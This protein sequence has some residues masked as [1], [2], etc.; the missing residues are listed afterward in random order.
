MVLHVGRA[1]DPSRELGQV[2]AADVLELAAALEF[3]GDRDKVNRVA[4]LEQCQDRCVRLRM[5]ALVER[6]GRQHLDSARDGLPLE[7][8]RTQDGLLDI[9]RLAEGL[10]VALGSLEAEPT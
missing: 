1:R 8:Q 5:A 2:V 6:V 4:A 9:D 10:R 3:L 7:Q